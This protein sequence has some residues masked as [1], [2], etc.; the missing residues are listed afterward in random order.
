MG[1][2]KKGIIKKVIV[3]LVIVSVIGVAGGLIWHNID[4]IK[5]KIGINNNKP[6][7]KPTDPEKPDEPLVYK[8]EYKIGE[9][10]K[11]QSV[12]VGGSPI[13]PE[14][15]VKEGYVFEGW[16]LDGNLI[17]DTEKVLIIKDTVFVAKYTKLY[18][19][20]FLIDLNN[21]DSNKTIT[22]KEGEKLTVPAVPV[23]EGYVFDGWLEDNSLIT[24]ISNIKASKDV[25]YTAKYT[26]IHTVTFTIQN[27]SIEKQVRNGE[28]ING[29]P[30]VE[31]SGYDF[32]GWVKD[33]EVVKNLATMPITSDMTFTAKLTKIHTVT[34]ELA[35]S[36]VTEK[37]RDGENI[38]F[39]ENYL[40]NG[41]LQL[42]F[43]GKS[44]YTATDKE[45]ESLNDWYLKNAS[46]MSINS[47]F[48]DIVFSSQ[49]GEFKQTIIDT[50]R[51]KGKTFTFGCKVSNA[52]VPNCYFKVV[53]ITENGEVYELPTK[54]T[55]D[56]VFAQTFTVEEDVKELQ[57]CIYSGVGQEIN[58]LR[59]ESLNLVEG[60][61]VGEFVKVNKTGY[62]FKGWAVNNISA[63]NIYT[64]PI[65]SDT[66]IKA[67]YTKVIKVDFVDKNSKIALTEKVKGRDCIQYRENIVT[68]SRFSYNLTETNVY[69][70]I[71]D[72]TTNFFPKVGCVKGWY[73]SRNY[74]ST[75]DVENKILATNSKGTYSNLTYLIVNGQSY[76]NKTL[77]LSM[78]T[79]IL[80]GRVQMS[81][82]YY[83][84][85]A[86][87]NIGNFFFSEIQ[88]DV[89]R[90]SLTA[91]VPDVEYDDL[92]I[93]IS[94][95]GGNNYS[96]FIDNVKLEENDKATSYIDVEMEGYVFKGWA[97]SV[98]NSNIV[99]L[100]EIHFSQDVVLYP[101]YEKMPVVKL[102]SEGKEL[103]SQYVNKGETLNYKDN[104]LIN[105]DF[106]IN[107]NN[108]T[109]TSERGEVV[110]GWE[111]FVDTGTSGNV[112]TRNADG[113]M[114][115][116]NTNSNK[117]TIFTQY[118]TEEQ[119][120]KLFNKTLTLSAKINNKTYY[121]TGNFSQVSSTTY[122]AFATKNIDGTTSMIRF[123]H[124]SN[125]KYQIDVWVDV[126]DCVTVSAV[127]FEQN[128]RPTQNV[129]PQKAGYKFLGWSLDGINVV[130]DISS[131]IITEDTTFNAVF[132][133]VIEQDTTLEL[134]EEQTNFILEKLTNTL[135][136]GDMREILSIEYEAQS[137][138][139]L[140][141]GIDGQRRE[142]FVYINIP[143]M[144][145]SNQTLTGE[146]VVDALSQEVVWGCHIYQRL[147]DVYEDYYNSNQ[148]SQYLINGVV[149]SI[150]ELI[151]EFNATY[152]QKDNLTSYRG[153]IL[154][155]IDN[156]VNILTIQGSEE[157]M[158]KATVLFAQVLD[159]CKQ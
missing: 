8:V 84:D 157:G 28:C 27:E 47:N 123:I 13:E 5:D 156:K 75:F 36:V 101:Q 92:A 61:E 86:M 141:K 51:Y 70:D 97:V 80:Q 107:E 52:V 59:L 53:K 62:E 64:Y 83:N 32:D 4:K 145:E 74:N 118:L 10:T 68:N 140:S 26:K 12:A 114:T 78:D 117:R 79:K 125:N 146:L 82:V 131:M 103:Y 69:G 111:Y 87:T 132:K 25:T 158:V 73:F 22:V 15:P 35:E 126:G 96:A 127:K 63:D 37:V 147:G 119:A 85:N 100:K 99:N 137:L 49:Y 7:E 112:L 19:V 102:V 110:E 24:D 1:K 40:S 11:S 41:D 60:N 152:S 18:T 67:T 120:T 3:G 57:I 17:E 88:E 133:K 130:D 104:L 44:S 58:S 55:K 134:T 6:I 39:K 153:G 124:N 34:I 45:I 31:I 46:I 94:V 148:D 16:Y 90:I 144:L 116:D 48:I 105:A 81:L 42:N 115:I 128:E 108:F 154:T 29:I 143:Y 122:K 56:G 151:V 76:K 9:E 21:P 77:S 66:A 98:N 71:D 30:V 93:L 138:N 38:K 54:I 20:T 142:K 33:G 150:N 135:H 65:T 43:N 23:K 95:N 91:T 113:S 106:S 121:C 2:H 136:D 149:C 109:S 129:I 72:I 14:A 50:T 139:C 159:A 155:F 89:T